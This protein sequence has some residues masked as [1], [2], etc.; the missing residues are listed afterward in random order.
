MENLRFP[1][2]EGQDT[3]C[4]PPVSWLPEG[5]SVAV[6]KSKPFPGGL[7]RLEIL[8]SETCFVC[9]R[10]RP[11]TLSSSHCKGSSRVSQSVHRGHPL[12]R[13]CPALTSKR[14]SS[15]I[16]L[17]NGTGIAEGLNIRTR[18]SVQRAWTLNQ[19]WIQVLAS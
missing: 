10:C 14:S 12:T 5:C 6:S 11:L 16:T 3:P 13:K 15:W 17:G 9:A 4:L 19:T 2:E 18:G 1:L 8:P 7:Y